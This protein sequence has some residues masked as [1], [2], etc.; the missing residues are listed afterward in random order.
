MTRGEFTHALRAYGRAIYALQVRSKTSSRT[1]G[2]ELTHGL[3]RAYVSRAEVYCTMQKYQLALDDAEA[4]FRLE[5]EWYKAALLQGTARRG[6]NHFET[7]IANFE[8]ALELV[9]ASHK[10]CIRGGDTCFARKRAL[11]FS[12][13]GQPKREKMARALE[14]A[15]T[16]W[17]ERDTRES[18]QYRDYIRAFRNRHSSSDAP[19][20]SELSP[21]RAGSGQGGAACHVLGQLADSTS[22]SFPPQTTTDGE[23]PGP[24]EL[25]FPSTAP[26]ELIWFLGTNCHVCNTH[27]PSQVVCTA[28]RRAFYCTQHAGMACD[29]A[30]VCASEKNEERQPS[31]DDI[32]AMHADLVVCGARGRGVVFGVSPHITHLWCSPTARTTCCRCRASASPSSASSTTGRSG[33]HCECPR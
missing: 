20:S 17:S 18:S 31:L 25:G 2:L 30:S 3:A 21:V 22:S 16:A 26:D 27:T 29:H 8:Q 13:L 4:A 6:L 12:L 33:S 5:P 19:L 24:M 7:A 15:K 23:A 10:V 32:L 1:K 11:T 9:S 14:E 28:C